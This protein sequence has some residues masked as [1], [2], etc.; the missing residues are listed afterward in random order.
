MPWKKCLFHVPPGLDPVDGWIETK[1]S[2]QTHKILKSPTESWNINWEE[3]GLEAWDEDIWTS[4]RFSWASLPSRDILLPVLEEVGFPRPEESRGLTEMLL[5]PSSP[6]LFLDRPQ[7]KRDPGRLLQMAVWGKHHKH[8]KLQAFD[9]LYWQ[10]H[11]EYV[12]KW[13]RDVLDQGGKNNLL[14]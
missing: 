6:S 8:E 11:R 10:K 1:F 13:I 14:D 4:F 5:L 12:W 9:N 7:L 3:V 2:S